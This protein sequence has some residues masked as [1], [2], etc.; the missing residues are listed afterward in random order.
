MWGADRGRCRQCGRRSSRDNDARTPH[1]H[2]AHNNPRKRPLVRSSTP[3][4]A[5]EAQDVVTP[6]SHK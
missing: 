4:R 1:N 3:Q 2:L 5:R 6:C